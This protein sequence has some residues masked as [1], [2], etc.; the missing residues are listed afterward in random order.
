MYYYVLSLFP[1]RRTPKPITPVIFPVVGRTVWKMKMKMMC[2]I[3]G[4]FF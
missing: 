1:D 4:E 3:L 2:Y